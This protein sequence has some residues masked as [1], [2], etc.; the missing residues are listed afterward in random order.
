[1][2]KNKKNIFFSF[3]DKINF[4][5]KKDNIKDIQS[6]KNKK[7]NIC[8]KKSHYDKHNLPL[9]KD[10]F[11]N[12]KETDIKKNNYISY[13]KNKF[14]KTK[15]NF[16]LIFK[17]FFLVNKIDTMFLKKLEE[18]LISS[19]ISFQT[20]KKIIDN[21]INNLNRK[22]IKNPKIVHKSIICEMKNILKKSNKKKKLKFKKLSIILLVGVNGSGKTT[23]AVKLSKLYQHKN[24]KVLVSAADTFRA[25]AVDQINILCNRNKIP[26]FFKKSGSDPASVV[27]E[28]IQKALLKDYDILIIDTAGRLHTKINLMNELKKIVRVINKNNNNGSLDIF[29]TID[30]C[31]GQNS[32]V[33]TD[34]FHRSLGV[35]GL[36]LTKFDGTAKGGII[37]SIADQFSIPIRY[38]T[39]GES[40]NDIYIFKINEFINTIFEKDL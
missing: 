34:L 21:S 6:V 8:L 36:I 22:D 19:D 16:S 18:K 10:N 12:R 4:F 40:I 28:S 32:L 33:Q 15:K 31:N 1:M 13:F 35:T 11:H 29:L 30:S 25:A 39:T 20:S 38:V 2:S 7:K 26:I 5:K 17:K 27:Y 9:K 3:I 14:I 24:K 37:F 23:T